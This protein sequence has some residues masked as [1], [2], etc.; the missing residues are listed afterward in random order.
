MRR[1]LIKTEPFCRR[2]ISS[3]PFQLGDTVNHP[4]AVP[5]HRTRLKMVAPEQAGCFSPLPLSG[6]LEAR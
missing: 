5:G 4:L 6:H 3:K 1:K 2:K